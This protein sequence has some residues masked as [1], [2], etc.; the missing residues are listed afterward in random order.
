MKKAAF[1]IAEIVLLVSIVAFVSKTGKSQVYEVERSDQSTLRKVE[2]VYGTQYSSIKGLKTF[3]AMPTKDVPMEQLNPFIFLNHHG[4][5]EFSVSN[6]GLPF[7]PHPHKGFETITFILEGDIQ[8]KDSKGFVSTIT[9]GGVQWMT[10][11]KGIIHSELSSREFKEKGGK[12]NILQLW[13][14]LPAALKNVEPNYQGLQQKDIP[15]IKLDNNKTTLHLISGKHNGQQGP[16]ESLTDLFMSWIDF[17]EGGTFQTEVDPE[18]VIFLYTVNGSLKIN[19]KEVNQRKLV[20]FSGDGEDID[21][22]AG[23]EST[24][25][26]GYGDPINEP[27]ASKGPFVMNTDEEIRKAY[28]DYQA[29]KF[30]TWKNRKGE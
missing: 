19:G 13:V 20:T 1:I 6:S 27:I 3:R 25:L 8:H 29:G 28:K 11:G 12:V 10:A 23:K 2:A 7:G 5:Q 9:S 30:G 18:K 16:A 17:S 26:F 14:N 4:P 21:I 15:A 22:K 24:I